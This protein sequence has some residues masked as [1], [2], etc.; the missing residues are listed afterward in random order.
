MNPDLVIA[1][2]LLLVGFL[3]AS[4]GHGGASGYIAVL[5]I[6]SIPVATYKPLIL[7]LNI[8]IASIA[9]IQFYRAGY[10]KWKTT[11][12]FLLTSIPCAF[13]GS[14]VHL[15]SDI[16]HLILGIALIIPVIR[17]IG[18]SPKE[19]TENK[20]VNLLLALAF[21][22]VIG[23]LSGLLNI[24]GGIFLSPILILMAW[25]NMK[26]A[27]AVS[28]LFIVLNSLSG[29]L[30]NLSNHVELNSS[31]YIWFVAAIMGGTTGAY[32]GSHRFAQITVKYLLSTVLLIAS[33][34]LI[35]FM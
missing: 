25:A 28:A 34:K 18:F 16:Y 9:F 32:F 24:G 26:E 30:G 27:A 2:S 5:S 20:P 17:L 11:W 8:I 19:S 12:P 29:L 31:S 23:F 6:F 1:L 10:F 15:A 35:F 7:V 3:Y 4:V 14:K 13:I 21:G 33:V 22:L